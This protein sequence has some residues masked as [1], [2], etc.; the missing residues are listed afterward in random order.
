MSSYYTQYSLSPSEELI[1][2]LGVHG[3]LRLAVGAQLRPGT[4]TPPTPPREGQ[5]AAPALMN[6]VGAAMPISTYRYIYVDMNIHVESPECADLVQ[7]VLDALGERH[8]LVLAL[9]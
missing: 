9:S 8:L 3:R 7:E 5:K 1:R 4:M 6:S 2:K